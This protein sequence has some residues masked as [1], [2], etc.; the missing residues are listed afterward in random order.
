MLDWHDSARDADI[1]TVDVTVVR[2]GKTSLDFG[3]IGRIENDLIFKARTVCVSMVAFTLE[4]I[5][6]PETVKAALGEPVDW[7]VPV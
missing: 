3:F 4:K 7:D 2:Y 5:P 6:I 1:V